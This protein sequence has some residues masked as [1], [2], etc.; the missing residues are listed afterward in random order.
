MNLRR[1][2]YRHMGYDY[3]SEYIPM[4]INCSNFWLVLLLSIS[5]LC[6]IITR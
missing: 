6:F 5:L 3:K 4:N 1:I 2:A